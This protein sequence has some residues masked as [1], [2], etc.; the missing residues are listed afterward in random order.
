VKPEL[1]V[2]GDKRRRFFKP[3]CPVRTLRAM[4]Y[5]ERG[6]PWRLRRQVAASASSRGHPVA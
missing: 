3:A 4:P 5:R 2:W 1:T 6:H